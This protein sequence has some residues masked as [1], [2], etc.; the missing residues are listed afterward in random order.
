[1]H[2]ADETQF[3][4]VALRYEKVVHACPEPSPIF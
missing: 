2:P 3:G 1:M 4:N